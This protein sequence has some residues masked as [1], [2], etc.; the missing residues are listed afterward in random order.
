MKVIAET[1]NYVVV[2]VPDGADS[3]DDWNLAMQHMLGACEK[4]RDAGYR[5]LHYVPRVYGWVCEKPLKKLRV[6]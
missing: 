2:K 3:A 4:L 5:P 6:D 1:T